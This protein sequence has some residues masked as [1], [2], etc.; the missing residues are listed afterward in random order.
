ML[1][2]TLLFIV[3]SLLAAHAQQLPRISYAAPAAYPPEALAA[4]LEAVVP[5]ELLIDETGQVA[6]ARVIEP[7]GDGFDEAALLAIRAFRF[8]PAL[9]ADGAP[10]PATIQYNFTFKAEAAPA[11][12]LEGRLLE[13]GVRAPLS[14]V[15]VRA[16][17]PNGATA[18]AVSDADGR[19]SFVGLPDGPWLISAV[20]PA[21]QRETQQV[22]VQTG[23]V[24]DATLYLIRDARLD[25]IVADEELVIEGERVTSEITERRLSAEEIQYLPGTNGDVIKV[26]QNLPGVARP[27]LGIGQLIIRGTAPENSRYFIDGTPIPLVFHFGGL[28][29]ILPSDVISEVAY[30]PGNYSVRYGRILGGLVDVRT[31]PELPERSRGYVS[32][33]VYQSAVFVEQLLGERTSLTFSGRRSYVDA[34][35]N[36]IL[37][38]SDGP[39][40]QAPRY[41][42]GQLRLLHRTERGASWDVLAFLSDD[43]FRFLGEPEEAEE[44]TGEEETEDLVTASLVDQFQRVRIRRLAAVGEWRQESAFSFGPE[45]RFFEFSTESDAREERLTAAYREEWTRPVSADRNTGFR[46]GLDVQGGQDEFA[47]FLANVGPREEG[48]SLFIAPAAYAESTLRWGPVTLIPGIRGDLLAY[49]TGYLATAVDPRLAGRVV[50]FRDTALKASVG[51]FSSFPSLRQASIEGDGNPDLVSQKSLQTSVG[52]IQPIGGRI[53]TEVTAFYNDLDDLV[54]GREDRIRFF[55]GP[56][57]A[58][59]FDTGAYANDGVGTIYGL[60][61]QA[62]YDGPTAVGLL[63]VT[64]SRSERQDRPDEPIELFIYDQPIVLN[65]LW[66]QQLPKNWRVGARG[67]FTSGNPFTPVVN[68]VYDLTTR[69]FIPVYG[70]RSSG[71][72][73]PFYSVDIRI[74]KTYTFKTWKLMTYLDLQNATFAQNVEVI[75]FNYDFTV[76]ENILSNPPL[77]V[78][79]LRGEW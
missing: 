72:I 64:L 24:V 33:D 68:R 63:T 57:P 62:R 54:V 40:F 23:S 55:T 67:R 47:F 34:V 56:P 18:L 13:A 59:P 8:T 21:F 38:S 10:V 29:S 46:L 32:V 25:S 61:A 12:S 6:D 75:T 4:G 45:R 71:R 22:N 5:L 77:P 37:N 44:E 52:L 58:G 28:T 65:A 74:D 43:R 50:L 17:G 69:T 35:L 48:E 19:F 60:E 49:D 41:Y 66:S 2:F 53:R 36:P 15:T 1:V 14:G 27:P 3:L 39:T 16:A 70:E 78:F 42:D 31:D 30:L 73:P 26:V 79:G 20:A 9:D 51:R 76:E 7:V 11:L